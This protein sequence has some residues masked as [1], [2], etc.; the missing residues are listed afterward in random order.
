MKRV[1]LVDDSREWL[2]LMDR[3][4]PEFIV[5]KADSFGTAKWLIQ[6]GEAYDLA[7]VDLNLV[8]D[9]NN[10]GGQADGL[11]DVILDLLHAGFPAT[12]R[13]ALTGMSAESIKRIFERH[14]LDDVLIKGHMTMAGLRE[15]VKR[16]LDR[17]SPPDPRRN[18]NPGRSVKS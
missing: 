13:I 12:R 4:L 16:A 7:I 18:T 17:T 6:T 8:E 3:A 14:D 11:G 10:F 15:A 5:E 2:D 9:V 1:L